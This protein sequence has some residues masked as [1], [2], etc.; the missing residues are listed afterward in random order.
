MIEYK[1]LIPDIK[2]YLAYKKVQNMSM[3]LKFIINYLPLYG[4]ENLR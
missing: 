2:Y 3:I 1:S 4:M